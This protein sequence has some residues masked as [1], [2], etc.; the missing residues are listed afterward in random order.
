M[1][2]HDPTDDLT[3][4]LRQKDGT[5]TV[6]VSGPVLT[7]GQALALIE[8]ALRGAGYHVPHESLQIVEPQ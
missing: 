1:S 7:T 6:T 4:T 2:D 8:D 5:R 3:I